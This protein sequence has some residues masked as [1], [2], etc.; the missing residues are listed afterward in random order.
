MYLKGRILQPLAQSTWLTP[1]SVLTLGM[2][3]DSSVLFRNRGSL[4]E[5]R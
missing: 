4:S 3:P 2:D 1:T 5:E